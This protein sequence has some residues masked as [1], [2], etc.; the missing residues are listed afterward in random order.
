MTNATITVEQ[1]VE[2]LGLH[3]GGA[4]WAEGLEAIGP[5]QVDVALPEG[6][7]ARQLLERLQVDPADAV[8]L[9][10]SIPSR[11]QT[12]EWWWLLERSV[13]RLTSAM[14]DPS[15]PH[16]GWPDWVAS[17]PAVPLHRRCFM[18]YVFLATVPHTRAWHLARGI[19]DDVSWASL[20]DLGRHMAVHRRAY[21]SAGVDA[22]WWLSL[23][24]RG[25]AFDFGR[26][27]FNYF[28]L[29]YGDETPPWYGWEAAADLGDGFRRNDACI[30]VHIPES[31]P[32]TPAACDES[33]RLAAEFFDRHFPVPQQGRRLATC[34]SW[35]LDDQLAAW[36]P[37]ESNIMRFQQRF[38]LVPGSAGG[39]N[40]ALSFVFR[41]DLP[42]EGVTS[43]FLD[44][45]SA[46]TTLE[47]ALV[48]HLRAGGEWRSRTGWVD[49][50]AG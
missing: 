50:S 28:S 23:C 15:E 38:E 27:Q 41:K 42:R 44:S 33:F 34:W 14:G 16:G 43:E 30:G 19:S 7:A 5:P 11:E 29:G 8:D 45:L 37:E 4:R 47:R 9:L 24:L 35:L 32:M 2:R 13:Q 40:S 20:V 46:R 3:G 6:E 48:S 36:L 22:A 1:V 26:L 10:S 49:L 25:E 18:A 39:D 21:G 17:K 12:P 31:G